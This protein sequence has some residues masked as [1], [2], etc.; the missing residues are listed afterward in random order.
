MKRVVLAALVLLGAASASQARTETWDQSVQRLCTS[1]KQDDCWVKAGSAICDK[2]QLICS[3]L[4]DHASA[5]V[6]RKA[7]KRWLVETPYGKGWVNERMM[8]IDSSK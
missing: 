4:P 1:T 5:K 3:N 7:G 2:D 6:I 8:M